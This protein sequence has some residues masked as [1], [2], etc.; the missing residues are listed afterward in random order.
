MLIDLTHPIANHM[1]VYPGDPPV[2][3]TETANVTTD[4]CQLHALAIGTHSSTHIDAPSHM[5]AGAASLDAIPLE[6]LTG[7][8]K[9]V[10]S[11]E[12]AAL[13]AA[14]FVPGDIAVL[15]SGASERFHAAD[16]WTVFPAL[17]TEA[18]EYLVAAGVKL[19]VLDTCSADNGDKSHPIHQILLGAGIP[20]I[21]N[22]TNMTALR[23]TDFVIRALP[24]RV[25]LDGAP[26]RVVAETPDKGAIHG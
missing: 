18:A 11:F 2:E 14:A 23:G 8:G 25:D 17:T 1:P 6:T 9:L 12:L 20:I 5:I 13:Q 24:L 3:V 10:E 16:Y 4:G 26:V 7:P 15:Y 19:V 21:E 22:A